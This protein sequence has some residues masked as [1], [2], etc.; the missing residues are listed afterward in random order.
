TLY[1][2]EL[3]CDTK[4]QTYIQI[5]IAILRNI[6]NNGFYRV[7]SKKSK[8][9]INIWRKFVQQSIK[10]DQIIYDLPKYHYDLLNDELLNIKHGYINMPTNYSKIEVIKIVIFNYLHTYQDKK[11]A[12][13]HV[14]KDDRAINAIKEYFTEYSTRIEF[15]E[16]DSINNYSEIA[17]DN[18]FIIIDDFSNVSNKYYGTR[19]EIMISLALKLEK[20]L[21]VLNNNYLK[22]DS[23]QLENINYNE[24]INRYSNI[25]NYYFKDGKNKEL[26]IEYEKERFVT[27]SYLLNKEINNKINLK[28]I[29]LNSAGDKSLLSAI[30]L[31]SKGYKVSIFIPQ[32]NSAKSG[33][34]KICIKLLNLIDRLNGKILYDK[35]CIDDLN[36]LDR[37]ELLL[38]RESIYMKLFRLGVI[39]IHSDM[40]QEVIEYMRY[41]IQCGKYK[42][43]IGDKI[44][45]KNL[46]KYTDVLII[47]SIRINI[48]KSWSIID[49]RLLLDLI[50]DF[51]DQINKKHII[52][53]NYKQKDIYKTKIKNIKKGLILNSFISQSLHNIELFKLNYEEEI[54]SILDSIEYNICEYI[55]YDYSNEFLDNLIYTNNQVDFIKEGQFVKLLNKKIDKLKSLSK[56]KIAVI[57]KSKA[58]LSCLDMYIDLKNKYINFDDIELI[59]YIFYNYIVVNKEYVNIISNIEYIYKLNINEDGIYNI[60][61]HWISE[62]D[63]NDIDTLTKINN[64]EIIFTVIEK[65]VRG[66]F[67]E[68]LC[69]LQNICKINDSTKLHNKLQYIKD[70]LYNGLKE[71]IFLEKLNYKLLDRRLTKKINLY[72]KKNAE[73]YESRV[74][75]VLLNIREYVDLDEFELFIIDKLIQKIK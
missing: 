62:Y 51:S 3:V 13:I 72:M 74:E 23:N 34:N 31:I 75:T 48:D 41:F 17:T 44:L 16:I 8:L 18:N 64:L 68:M 49:D 27:E 33:I 40:P 28:G 36:L 37:A 2:K 54:N 35:N 39:V 65:V 7:I 43:I 19:F 46:S 20:R 58:N 26:E 67:V 29:K 4:D 60:I 57:Y 63:Y 71:N 14:D 45:T 50:N 24:D 66:L 70:I 22:M 47:N 55:L 52:I 12:Y 38:G 11:I 32:K 69:K 56:D 6:Q 53:S 15:I 10:Y 25:V 59:N 9:D 5:I 30:N 42:I 1:E 61:L 73:L 21:L